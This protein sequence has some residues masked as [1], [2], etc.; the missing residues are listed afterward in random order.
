MKKET[1]WKTVKWIEKEPVSLSIIFLKK[2]Q[3][4]RERI[5]SPEIF[6]FDL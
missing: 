5:L 2:L 1:Q 4:K 3:T 6:E